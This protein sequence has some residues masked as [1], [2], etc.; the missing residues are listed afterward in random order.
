MY[1]ADQAKEI[2]ASDADMSGTGDQ[3]TFTPAVPVEIVEFGYII[4][5]VVVDAAGGLVLKADVRPTAGSDTSRTDG[6]AGTL[7]LTTAQCN[8]L[9]AGRV[10]RS[11]PTSPLTVLSGQQVVLELTTAP[12]SG[13]GLPYIVY[14]EK[15]AYRDVATAETVVTA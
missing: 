3:G 9:T 5:T 14:R 6:T 15:P 12:D 10:M 2:F 11:R 13:A 8:A 4:T 1:T 7:T